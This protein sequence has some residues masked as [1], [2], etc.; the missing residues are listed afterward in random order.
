VSGRERP[1]HFQRK[2]CRFD[3]LKNETNNSRRFTALF[4]PCFPTERI[5]QGCCDAGFQFAPCR[6][7]VKLRSHGSEMARP[8]YLQQRTCLMS[9]ATAGSCH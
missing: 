8:V 4:L 1:R 7:R 9:V 2:K 3:G 5:A 6:L